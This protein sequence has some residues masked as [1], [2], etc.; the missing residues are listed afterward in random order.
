MLP[1]DLL[2]E[3]GNSSYLLLENNKTSRRSS[4]RV[5]HLKITD[6][7]VVSLLTGI[8]GNLDKDVLL[9]SGS[10]SAFRTRWNF[11]LTTLG[12]YQ[13]QQHLLLEGYAAE[14][15]LKVIGVV[16]P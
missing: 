2:D 12:I 1:M 3:S 15:Q 10:P 5:Q 6:E 8:Y 4:A 16:S 11:L 7:H 9:F 13:F 14:E